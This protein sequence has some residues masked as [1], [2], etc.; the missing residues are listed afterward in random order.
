V[1]GYVNLLELMAVSLDSQVQADQADC[2]DRA[3]QG[4]EEA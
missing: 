3:V 4:E 1:V 2:A